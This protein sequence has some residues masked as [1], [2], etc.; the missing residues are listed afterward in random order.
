MHLTIIKIKVF[1]KRQ[2]LSVETTLSEYTHTS[3]L[4]TQKLA[5]TSMLTIQNLI[6]TQIT[7]GR[8]QRPETVEINSTET[9]NMA[10]L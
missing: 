6:Y 9:E 10:G 4:H 1:I 5:H 3:V 2:L 8:K 7:T